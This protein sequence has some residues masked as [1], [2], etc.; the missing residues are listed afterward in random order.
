MEGV[1]VETQPQLQEPGR[2]VPV[3][4]ASAVPAPGGGDHAGLM[5]PGAARPAARHAAPFANIFD[6]PVLLPMLSVSF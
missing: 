2:E 3:A 6:S 1:Q 5:A 4:S